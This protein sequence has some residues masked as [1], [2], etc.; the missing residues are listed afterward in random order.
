TEGRAGKR[1][2][3]DR[4]TL[5]RTRCAPSR[6]RNHID[7]P[8]PDC[9]HRKVPL[10]AVRAFPPRPG[11]WILQRL[12]KAS[13]EVTDMN[14]TAS[15][16]APGVWLASMVWGLLEEKYGPGQVPS[17]RKLTQHIREANQ[18]GTISHSHVHN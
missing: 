15:G 5:C 10:F 11:L 17:V 18:G 12:D 2:G 13:A 9:D 6:H 3:T 4:S 1:S 16:D 14:T 8:R 7:A